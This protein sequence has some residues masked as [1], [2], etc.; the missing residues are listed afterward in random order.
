M[1]PEEAVWVREHVWTPDMRRQFKELPGFYLT[2]A[3]QHNGPCLNAKDPGRHDRCHVG[4]NPLPRCETYID[5]PRGYAAFR[6]PYRYPTADATGWKFSTL[7]MVWL[8]DRRCRWACSCD[9]GHL[10]DDIAH[11][12]GCNPMRPIT[13]ELVP[14]FEEVA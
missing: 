9:C 10:R 13:Y 3:C 4:R 6:Q 5:T 8:A 12:P 1:T 14:L 11:D 2:C 7:A